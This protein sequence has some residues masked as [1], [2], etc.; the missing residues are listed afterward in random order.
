M[1]LPP[2]SSEEMAAKA[3]ESASR[4]PKHEIAVVVLTQ[5]DRPAELAR[6]IASVRAQQQVDLQLV[7]VV[8]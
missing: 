6:A 5:A 3:G 4:E 8:N 2:A 1:T 7:L